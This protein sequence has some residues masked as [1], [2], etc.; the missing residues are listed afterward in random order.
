M[1]SGSDTPA[2]G[3]ELANGYMMSNLLRMLIYKGVISREDLIRDFTR[4][5][6]SLAGNSSIEVHV[7]AAQVVQDTLDHALLL[8][9]D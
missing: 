5:T 7:E 1:A 4:L 8:P 9:S 6:E 3:F 2:T